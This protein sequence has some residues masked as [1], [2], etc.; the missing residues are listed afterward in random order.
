MAGVLV[1]LLLPATGIAGSIPWKLDTYAYM[2]VD[3][4]LE[5]FLGDFANMEGIPY[6]VSDKVHGSVNGKFENVP[7]DTLLHNIC[8]AYNLSYFYDG[9][10]LYF[11]T[12]E[13]I[14]SDFLVASP[15]T[16]DRMLTLLK[17]LPISL[18][19]VQAQRTA[20]E[21]VLLIQGP[22]RFLA[23]MNELRTRLESSKE[24]MTVRF[25][26]L[27]HAW[28]SDLKFHYRNEDLTVPG[29]ASAI[30]TL[31]GKGSSEPAAQPFTVA[32]SKALSGLLGRGMGASASSP[33]PTAGASLNPSP[34]P[35]EPRTEQDEANQPQAYADVRLNAVI[36]RD[37]IDRMAGYEKLIEHLDVPV[38]IMEINGAI[39]DVNVERLLSLG[40]N[41][42]G[43]FQD[44]GP[45]HNLAISTQTG[46]LN[47]PALVLGTAFGFL[48]QIRLMERKGDARIVSR[49]SVLTMDNLEATIRDDQT[50]FLPISGFM[51]TDVYPV[52]TGT[53]LKVV[54]HL[55]AQS[56]SPPTIRLIVTVIDG[57]IERSLATQQQTGTVASGLGLANPMTQ[58]IPQ[59]RETSLSTQANVRE[60]QSVLIAGHLMETNERK[61]SGLPWIQ[62]VPLLGYLFKSDQRT[63]SKMERMFLI[64]PRVIDLSYSPNVN[65][66]DL[67]GHQSP[68][69]PSFPETPRP[70]SLGNPGHTTATVGVE[71]KRHALPRP[72]QPRPVS[73]RRE[74]SGLKGSSTPVKRAQPVTTS[75]NDGLPA[76][77][78]PADPPL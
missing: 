11:Y 74:N 69:E 76:N 75:V 61:R 53:E 45:I 33:L 42:F 2:A 49:P 19:T 5:Q 10:T 32:R 57:K 7:P 31:M 20:E 8:N 66:Q 48:D 21:G 64:T 73:S 36:V 25:F 50:F 40:T 29:V 70:P 34:P 60:G 12:K 37:T 67:L 65:P 27:R 47:L 72:A 77:Q 24:Q 17:S 56:G 18:D 30:Q 3:T 62:D 46:L 44:N 15:G 16:I 51:A 6:S 54:P 4:P 68:S 39:L 55:I 38:K 9:L 52:T 41:A 14:K 43:L 22:P 58:S 13:E 23:M 63:V 26:R 59:I 35:R 1:L 28:A 78:T 71:P